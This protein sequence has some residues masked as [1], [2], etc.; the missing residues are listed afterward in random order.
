MNEDAR[1]F[2]ERALIGMR[3]IAG[4][5]DR[6][7]SK[8]LKV[9]CRHKQKY[10]PVYAVQW[11]IGIANKALA[12]LPK[13]GLGFPNACK[14]SLELEAELIASEARVNVLTS[15]RNAL[16]NAIEIA[17]FR[18]SLRSGVTLEIVPEDGGADGR[19]F[20]ILREL[21]EQ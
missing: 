7:C 12:A 19:N 6:M 8:C 11:C 16:L 10:D 18:L 2:A 17:G 5:P 13:E 21:P 1:T 14:T 4:I 3:D 15:Q 20:A 9:P